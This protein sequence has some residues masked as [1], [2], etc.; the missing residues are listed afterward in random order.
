MPRSESLYKVRRLV[1]LV[2][3]DGSTAT[4]F[5]YLSI[6]GIYTGLQSW[7][8][9]WEDGVALSYEEAREARDIA[10]NKPLALDVVSHAIVPCQ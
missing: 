6:A 8:E 5:Q 10:R 1:E 7:T 2:Q 9:V 4:H 3:E